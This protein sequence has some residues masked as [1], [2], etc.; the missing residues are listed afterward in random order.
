MFM[1]ITASSSQLLL[2]HFLFLNAFFFSFFSFFF[3]GTSFD[4][5]R[6]AAINPFVFFLYFLNSLSILLLI[7]TQRESVLE[8]VFV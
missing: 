7:F 5:K 1:L 3:N 2:S 8:N 6:L 4:F